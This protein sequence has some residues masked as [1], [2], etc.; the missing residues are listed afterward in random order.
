V[1]VRSDR[2]FEFAVGP[3]ELWTALTGVDRY[4]SWWP[5]LHRFE[6]TSFAEGARWRCAVRAPLGYPVRFEV[7][8]ERVVEG[9]SA[10]ASVAGDI[11]G[12]ARLDVEAAGAG[13]RLHL[14]STLA[15]ERWLLRA[16]ARLAPPVARFGHDRL[17]DTGVRQF[18]IRAFPR[19]TG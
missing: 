16:I 8:L 11:A 18:R 2:W 14:E 13:S 9:R 17:L 3:A 7:V 5:W 1:E 12:R 19:P 15:S 10:A 4:R 6:G